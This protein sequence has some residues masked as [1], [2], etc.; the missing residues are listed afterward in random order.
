MNEIFAMIFI[1]S[2]TKLKM[3]M[4]SISTFESDSIKRKTNSMQN[5][6]E[7]KKKNSVRVVMKKA[8]KANN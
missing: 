5:V 2:A 7:K 1:K 4:N 3:K 6:T 8:K